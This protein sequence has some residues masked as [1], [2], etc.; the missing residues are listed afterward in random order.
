VLTQVVIAQQALFTVYFF[1]KLLAVGFLIFAIRTALA[2][3][4]IGQAT[5]LFWTV[6]TPLSL[7]QIGVALV[8]R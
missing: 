4:K 5:R 3:V 7:L 8:I 2:R 1:V 6:L